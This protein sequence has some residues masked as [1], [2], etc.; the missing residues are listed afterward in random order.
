M[1]AKVEITWSK[2]NEY[3]AGKP[4]HISHDRDLMTA[5]L[6][7]P[8]ID[9]YCVYPEVAG[10]ALPSEIPQSLKTVHCDEKRFIIAEYALVSV[11]R[12]PH[13]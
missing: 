6:D 10:L 7:V 2:P 5:L 9:A 1:H 12:T 13:V 8:L 11:T 3:F 4:V